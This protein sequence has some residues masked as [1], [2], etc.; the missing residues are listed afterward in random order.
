M[1]QWSFLSHVWVEVLLAISVVISK[2]VLTAFVSV[3]V[4]T[5]HCGPWEKYFILINSLYKPLRTIVSSLVF[6]HCQF[7]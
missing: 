7:V 3:M 6:C 1:T 2:A 5:Y 4:D